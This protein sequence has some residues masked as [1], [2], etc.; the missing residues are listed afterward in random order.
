MLEILQLWDASGLPDC[1]YDDGV[2]FAFNRTSG[3]VFLVNSD[4]QC[5]MIN[6]GKLSMFYSTP[7]NGEEGFLSDLLA[8]SPDKYHDEDAEYIRECAKN[9]GVTLPANWSI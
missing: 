4:Y 8:Q 7:Y 9:E 6:D 5:V 3:N 2:K 1:F